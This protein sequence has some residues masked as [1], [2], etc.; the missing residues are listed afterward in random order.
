[1]VGDGIGV[2]AGRVADRDSKPGRG[3]EV[4]V[5]HA[6]S[7]PGDNPQPGGRLQHFP[8]KGMGTPDDY[9]VDRGRPPR[10]FARLEGVPGVIDREAAGTEQSQ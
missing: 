6:H 10:G 3:L 4:D 2:T 9:R 7:L 1:M 5:V 8:A